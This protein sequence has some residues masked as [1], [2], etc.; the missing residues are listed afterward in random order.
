MSLTESKIKDLHDKKFDDLYEKHKPEWWAM[1]EN[2]YQHAR[3]H[4]CDGDHPRQDDV[5]KVLVPML[6]PNETLRKHQ[7]DNHARYK[8]FRDFFGEYII[9]KYYEEL[10]KEHQK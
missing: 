2:A 4:I 6:E 10:P 7:E 5:L 9:D 1:A 3:D 8:R